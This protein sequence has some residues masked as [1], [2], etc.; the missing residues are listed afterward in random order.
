MADPALLAR[1]RVATNARHARERLGWTQETAAERID[2]SVQALQRMERATAAPTVNFLAQVA[3]SYGIDLRELF[4]D[5]GPWRSP[6]V[7]RPAAATLAARAAEREAP[8]WRKAPRR[9]R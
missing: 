1:R 8:T 7:G 6:A 2:C 9:R 5:V 4:A 3:V